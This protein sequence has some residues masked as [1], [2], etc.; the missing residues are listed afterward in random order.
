MVGVPGCG[1]FGA[2]VS[3]SISG[4]RK[5]CLTLLF[6]LC[7]SR[8]TIELLLSHTVGDWGFFMVFPE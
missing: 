8:I 2:F 6:M 3:R 5:K 7:L 4:A 1:S